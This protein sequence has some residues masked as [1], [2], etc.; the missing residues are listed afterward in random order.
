M[1]RILEYNGG[2]TVDLSV[3]IKLECLKIAQ[4]ALPEDALIN[5]VFNNGK[6]L[7]EWCLDPSEGMYV[8]LFPPKKKNTNIRRRKKK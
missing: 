2:I 7:A 6:K 4:K 3:T 1:P 5:D 8:S